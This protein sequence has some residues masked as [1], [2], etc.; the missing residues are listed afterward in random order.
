M[1]VGWEVRDPCVGWKPNLTNPVRVHSIPAIL[2]VVHQE[3]RSPDPL[4]MYLL[5]QRDGND[6]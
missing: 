4:G 5:S 2:K 1:V 3:A 6:T